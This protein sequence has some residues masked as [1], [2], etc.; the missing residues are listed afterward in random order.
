MGF[1]ISADVS[2]DNTAFALHVLTGVSGRADRLGRVMACFVLVIV[3]LILAAV[4]PAA[5]TGQPWR[6]PGDLGLS[7][8]AFLIALGVSS[9]ASAR[10]TYAVPLPGDNPMKTPPGS[11]ARVAVTQL[12]TFGIMGVLLIPTLVP[13]VTGWVMHSTLA[14]YITLAV[15]LITG[16]LMLFFGI[17]IGGRTMDQRAPELMQSV[18]INR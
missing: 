15:G 5:L 11:G 13:Y 4:L 14:G 3:P 1:S 9:I 2:Y 17:R 18:M 10:Y 7:F 16:S 6:I 12:A 8:G